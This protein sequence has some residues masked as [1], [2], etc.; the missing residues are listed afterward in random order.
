MTF[1]YTLTCTLDTTAA[2]PPVTGSEEQRAY[3]VTPAIVAWPLS[4]LPRGMDREVVV[5]DAGDPIPGSGLALRLITAPGGG[6]AAIHGRILGAEGMPAPTVTPL[7]I[8]GNLPGEV[9]AAH[10]H[11][12]GYIALSATDADGA[13][14]L[15]DDAVASALTGQ[16][17]IAQY[18][19]LPDPT[20]AA[21]V[22]GARLDAFT[23][24]QTAILLD[25]LYAEAATRAE[26]GVTFTGGLPSFA[27]W[28]PTAQAVTLLTWETGD[29]LGSVPEVPGP[30]RRT[31]AVRSSDG[32]WV[33]A[34]RPDQPADAV[35]SAPGGE[36][37]PGRPAAPIT[38]GCQYL[39]E[40]RVYVPSTRRVETN[41]VTDPYSTALTTDSTRSVAVDL[42]DPRL[43][44]ERWATTR[45]PAV[46]NDSARSIYEL[47]LRDFSA[48]DGTV[49]PELRGTY[50][51]FTVAGSAG[52]R[53][54]A[55]L[56]RAG[57][58][59]IHLL[60]TFDIASI[61]VTEPMSPNRSRPFRSP[62][63]TLRSVQRADPKVPVSLRDPNRASLSSS[64]RS[65]IRQAS[66]S[67]SDIQTCARICIPS[68]SASTRTSWPLLAA[69]V[70]ELIAVVC[71]PRMGGAPYQPKDGEFPESGLLSLS[72]PAF[73][74]T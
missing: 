3:W 47:H 70:S 57:M 25:H 6:A 60:P 27:L 7:R 35:A 12:E 50:R 44:P 37:G 59:T 20:E 19:G 4:L 45:A 54:L 43:A 16:V 9:L 65:S 56:A 14:L 51:A 17:A 41:V 49:P 8:V 40:V 58:N 72:A 13:P 38:A 15:D 1:T 62:S 29:P 24:V 68:G 67:A 69:P 55:E 66:Q 63:S 73:R 64:S 21:D 33:V 22:S 36:P 28:A 23:G 26:L 48:A 10:P 11:L 32:R 46:R 61:P 30:P 74:K 18:V 71:R 34:N 52:V 2:L 31:P 5:T 53:H 39:W 42:A